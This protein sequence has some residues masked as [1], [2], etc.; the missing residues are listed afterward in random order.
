MVLDTTPRVFMLDHSPNI[1]TIK[2]LMNTNG[3]L[4]NTLVHCHSV[5]LQNLCKVEGMNS[6][7]FSYPRDPRSVFPEAT[8]GTLVS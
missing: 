8:S 5:V 4:L 3:V 6:A 7:L 2:K 1:K